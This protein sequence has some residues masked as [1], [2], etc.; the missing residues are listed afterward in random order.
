MNHFIRITPI[1]VV[2]AAG[3]QIGVIETP[4]ALKMAEEQGLDLVEISPEARP[5]VCKIMDF[6][7]FKYELSKQ[8]KNKGAK[9]SELKEVRL[10]RSVKID[11]HDVGIRVKQARRF[12]LEGNKVQI[13]QRFRGREMAHREIGI[14]RLAEIAKTLSEVGK[15]EAPPRWNGP[16]AYIIVAPDKVKC[17]AI[18]R[19]EAKA[20]AEALKRGEKIKEEV[21]P[22][23]P[24]DDDDDDD[25]LDEVDGQEGHGPQPEPTT[26]PEAKKPDAK[27]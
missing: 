11:P 21:I 8:S 1:R 6:G 23:L 16:Q 15:I 2:G 12:L 22:E 14:N 5:P 13:T 9:A 19:A 25:L 18:K 17:E 10:G 3:E 4:V 27:A 26:P 24:D 7:K 20:R